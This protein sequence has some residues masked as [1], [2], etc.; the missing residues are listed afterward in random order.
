M[1]GEE[2]QGELIEMEN[3]EANFLKA[4]M[5][6]WRLEINLPDW[7]TPVR[8]AGPI[9]GSPEGLTARLKKPHKFGTTR[10]RDWRLNETQT[11]VFWSIKFKVIP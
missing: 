1:L 11:F 5:K 6:H 9:G 3:Q 7:L 2:E 4:A 10:K 8:Q